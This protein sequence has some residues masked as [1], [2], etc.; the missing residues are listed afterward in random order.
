[1][2]NPIHLAAIFAVLSLSPSQTSF[3]LKSETFDPLSNDSVTCDN[4]ASMDYISDEEQD[5]DNTMSQ[6]RPQPVPPLPVF[7]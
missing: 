6:E 1:M 4:C 3:P 7:K 5:L 2:R